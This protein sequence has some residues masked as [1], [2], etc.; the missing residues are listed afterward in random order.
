MRAFERVPG[1]ECPGPAFAVCVCVCVCVEER[2]HKNT[3]KTMCG[4]LQES[5][6]T[7]YIIR[8]LCKARFTT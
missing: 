7:Q 3:G 4:G 5:M 1:P 8:I 2:E 6:H